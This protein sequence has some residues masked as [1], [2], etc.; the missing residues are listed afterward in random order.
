[1][2]GTLPETLPRAAFRVEST[3]HNRGFLHVQTATHSEISEVLS[4]LQLGISASELH[5][6]LSGYLC[7]GGLTRAAS[8]LHELALDEIEDAVDGAPE[9]EILDRLFAG[10]T[11]E[12]EDPELS[13][14]LMLPEDEAPM[15]ERAVA[16]VDWCRGFL[17]GLGL[18]GADL[19]HGLGSE[20]REIVADLARIAAT[21]FEQESGGEEDENAY[22]EVVEYVRVGTMLLHNELARAPRDATRH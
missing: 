7:A 18:S 11:A 8:W 19:D 10:C 9:R 3:P 14:G 15:P 6:S 17:G 16:L 22:A 21:S 5:G 12:L 20:A 1:M 2:P 4:A 13:F